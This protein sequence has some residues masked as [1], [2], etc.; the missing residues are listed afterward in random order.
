MRVRTDSRPLPCPLVATRQPEPGYTC[1]H[2]RADIRL[3]Y[4]QSRASPRSF[5][6]KALLAAGITLQFAGMQQCLSAAWFGVL[7][8][9]TRKGKAV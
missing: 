6:S 9:R 4:L 1:A 7:H 2:L 5:F 8:S 3:A